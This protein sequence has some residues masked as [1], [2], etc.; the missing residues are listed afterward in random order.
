MQQFQIHWNDAGREPQCASHPEYPHGI[1]LDVSE[2]ETTTCTV[3]LPYPAKRC[4]HYDV[5]CSLCGYRAIITTAGRAD[6]PR[7]VKL[8]CIL[9]GTKQ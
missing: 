6:D 5:S 3:E 4:G 9:K 1:D 8:P 2:G 7:S